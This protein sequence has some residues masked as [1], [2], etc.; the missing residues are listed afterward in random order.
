M[1]AGVRG[2]RNHEK[3]VKAVSGWRPR[4]GCLSPGVKLAVGGVVE[5]TAVTC[6]PQCLS[7]WGSPVPVI[8]SLTQTILLL[9]LLEAT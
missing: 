2:S 1:E 4:L 5:W 6:L 9:P 7:V 8:Y 3:Q